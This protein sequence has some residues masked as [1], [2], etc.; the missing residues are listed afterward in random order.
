M[1]ALR[2]TLAASVA[3]MLTM[4]A[5]TC[6]AQEAAAPAL[7][8]GDTWKWREIDLL[9]KNEVGRWSERIDRVGGGSWWMLQDGSK[10][11]WWRG[12]AAKG[13]RLEQF[14]VADDQ[15]E[16]RGAQVGSADGGFA[17]RW[18]M[19]VGD[20]FDCTENTVF[21]NGWK[22]K[23]EL[24][25]SVEAAETVEVPAGKFETLRIVAKGFYTNATQNNATGRHE[26]SFWYAPAVRNEVKREY[27][28]WSPRS[29]SP[30][31]VE[32]HELVEFV[33]GA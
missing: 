27:R 16:R 15:P 6:L 8:V 1:T 10:R 3:A 17:W 31:R 19:K 12:D 11:S 7:K 25:C 26:R 32:G 4:A 5:A 29:A 9:T 30:I 23:Y 14:A 28:T 13:A 18:P 22:L 2:W 20:S 21:P 24:K 33:A